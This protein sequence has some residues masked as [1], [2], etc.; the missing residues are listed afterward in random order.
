MALT[1]DQEISIARIQD[2][3]A[4]FNNTIKEGSDPVRVMVN[5]VFSE[6]AHG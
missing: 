3:F 1:K 4:H 6:K 5:A 2:T